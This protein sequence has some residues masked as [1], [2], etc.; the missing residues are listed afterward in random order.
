M[1]IDLTLIRNL[2]N[3]NNLLIQKEDNLSEANPLENM[4]IIM[5]KIDLRLS[6]MNAHIKTYG[7]HLEDLRNLLSENKD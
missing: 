5:E 6:D 2:S 7:D 4:I 3:V 1:P